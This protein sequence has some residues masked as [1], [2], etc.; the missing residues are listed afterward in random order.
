[1]RDMGLPTSGFAVSDYFNILRLPDRGQAKDQSRHDEAGEG[2]GVFHGA[3]GFYWL[4]RPISIG[5][6][7][8]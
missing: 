8:F 6:S 7:G 2:G 3:T 5:V 4:S 1:M